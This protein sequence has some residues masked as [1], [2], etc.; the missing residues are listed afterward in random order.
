MYEIKIIYDKNGNEIGQKS[1]LF[2]ELPD[3]YE[4]KDCTCKPSVLNLTS[5]LMAMN[6]LLNKNMI[7]DIEYQ[8]HS[9]RELALD[10][11]VSADKLREAF[12]NGIKS[13]NGGYSFNPRFFIPCAYA[14]RH[15]IEL[16]LKYAILLKT[17]NLDVLKSNHWIEKLWIEFQNHYTDERISMLQQF[18]NMIKV[19]DDD[20][21]KLRYNFDKNGNPYSIDSYYFDVDILMDNTKYFFNVVDEIIK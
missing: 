14:C 19:I 21:I 12:H 15:S 6:V 8:I 16:L 17:R 3:D 4:F 1:V 9:F 5:E 11:V 2:G 13:I 18:I 20:G 7:P 10:Y